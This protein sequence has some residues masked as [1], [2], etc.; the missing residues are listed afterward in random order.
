MKLMLYPTD[1]EMQSKTV[2]I[3]FTHQIGKSDK[4]VE[5]I[6]LE[7]IDKVVGKVKHGLNQYSH[8]NFQVKTFST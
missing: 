1:R 6:L 2:K 4:N 8:F 5:C 7:C 3:F